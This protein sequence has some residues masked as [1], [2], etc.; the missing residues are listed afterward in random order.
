M[1]ARRGPGGVALVVALFAACSR[2][3]EPP[4]APAAAAA[5]EKFVG[6]DACRPCHA[7][8]W[9]TFSRTGMGRAWYPMAE[10]PVIEDWSK[11]NAL[12]VPS[13]GLRYRMTRRDGKFFMR[14]SIDDG[15]GGETAVDERELVWVVGSGN[16][17]TQ[18]LIEED[19]KLFQAPVCW[20]TEARVWDLCPGYE[21]DNFYFAREINRGCVFCHNDRM[22]LL[23]GARNAFQEP[24][25]HGIGC[26]RCHG[27]GGA[28]VAK[29]EQGASPTGKADPTVVNPKRLPPDLRLQVC[30]PCHLGDA[31][32][33]ERVALYQASLE[34]WRPGR[35]ITTAV[36]PYRFSQ[37]TVHDFGLSAQADR[38]M[39]SP[40]FK[41]SGGK[42]ECL[43][44]HNP[45]RTIFRADRPAD[46]FTSK[47]LG[48]HATEACTASTAMRHAT[49]P[50]DDCV[51]CHMRKGETDDQH[52]VSYTDH[53]I[54]TRIDQPQEARTL[55][56]VE[57]FFP[58]LV[59]KLSPADQAF[60]MA[61]AISLRTHVVPPAARKVMWP[62]A[63][64][65]FREALA[66][67]YAKADG[68]YFL[69]LALSE[70]GKHREAA[71]AYA[72]AYSRE[73]TDFD[74]AFAH[75]Q[76]LIRQRRL[77]EA[78]QVFAVAAKDNP[79]AAGPLA[80]RARARAELRDYA[81][82]LDLF[83][84]A[85]ALEPWIPSIRVNAAK[86]LS[87]LERHSEAIA[88]VEEALRRDPEGAKTWNA[89][90][91]LLARAGRTAD[92]EVAARRAKE[93]AKAPGLRA[94][95]VRPGM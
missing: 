42:L 53:W 88:E 46:Y 30:F 8:I 20:H 67:G 45:H 28:H 79:Q 76:A 17:S 43:T 49:K 68:P 50:P 61:R 21:Y 64:S 10:A 86:M 1:S 91:T 47:C 70:Q 26:E 38:M 74:I 82:A 85:S 48:C 92:A 25:P 54:R 23:P 24:I 44:C 12:E 71:E 3:T 14:Q 62:Q 59:S 27:P 84:K 55:F 6:S 94:S 35:P 2:G 80:E 19:G 41:E 56:D 4:S 31:K 40:C 37:V 78:E 75:G 73:P 93:L 5:G 32:A 81:G 57:P 11:N 13:T 34:D 33:T 22:T 39:Q 89:Y 9:S 66:A 69:G 36:I 87:A 77:E 18:Y 95:D 90:A 83:R 15:R 7:E 51:A 16:H 65:K 63:E 58:E 52:H 60:Y 29:W 72:A